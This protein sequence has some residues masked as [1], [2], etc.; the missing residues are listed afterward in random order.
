[1]SS[2]DILSGDAISGVGS[3][4]DA[5]C[6]AGRGWHLALEL[7]KRKEEVETQH[8]TMKKKRGERKNS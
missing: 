1:M 2:A 6:C 8:G 3:V 7:L 4:A 5:E